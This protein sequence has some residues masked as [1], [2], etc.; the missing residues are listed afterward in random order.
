M[1]T[2]EYECE[3]C[4]ENFE[5]L[6]TMSEPPREKCE[7]CGGH[8]RKLVS[9]GAGLIFKGS[10][11]YITD[12]KSSKEGEKK[13]EKPGTGEGDKKQKSAEG[14]SKSPKPEGA[15]ETKSE[16]PAKDKKN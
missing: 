4:G 12:Y 2:Y 11:F 9:S 5:Y 15:S 6:Q 14:E 8:L 10:G 16:S 7:K 1:P 13:T 3:S